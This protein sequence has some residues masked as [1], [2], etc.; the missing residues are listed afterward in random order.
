MLTAL[1]SDS[2]LNTKHE[3]GSFEVS[4]GLASRDKYADQ[5]SK[6]N[7]DRKGFTSDPTATAATLCSSCNAAL[8]TSCSQQVLTKK[9]S[10]N[11]Y[12]HLV[13]AN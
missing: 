1:G 9:K 12:C 2:I 8:P 3:L 7:A 4:A 13:A 10:D 6:P 11:P 5:R